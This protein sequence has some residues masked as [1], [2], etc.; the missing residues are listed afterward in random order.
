[1]SLRQDDHGIEMNAM[2]A[3]AIKQLLLAG[4]T[5]EVIYRTMVRSRVRAYLGIEQH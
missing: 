5:A 3:H 4:V 2:N 1:M